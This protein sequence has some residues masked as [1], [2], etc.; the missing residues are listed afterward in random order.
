MNHFSPIDP[1]HVVT[2]PHSPLPG[3]QPMSLGLTGEELFLV[4][5]PAPA[6]LIR[7]KAE[8]RVMKNRETAASRA[9]DRVATIAV[10]SHSSFIGKSFT[11]D[12]DGKLQKHTSATFYDGSVAIRRA[13]TAADLAAI[14]GGL[15]PSRDVLALG[16]L[17]DGRDA[18]RVT[19]LGRATGDQIARTKQNFLHPAAP[20]WA[21]LD[22]DLGTATPRARRQIEA[23]GGP[24]SALYAAVP[25]LRTSCHVVRPSSS[26]GVH[27]EGDQPGEVVGWHVLVK[28]QDATT[29]DHFIATVELRLWL[30]GLAWWAVSSSGSRLPRGLVDNTVGGPE[31]LIFTADPVLDPGVLRDAP[32]MQ[33]FEGEALGTLQLAPEDERLAEELS[34]LEYRLTKPEADRFYHKWRVAAAW[35]IVAKT[36]IDFWTAFDQVHLARSRG[37]LSDNVLFNK[38]DGSKGRIGDV[39][40]WAESLPEASRTG[41][42][43][44]VCDP[45]ETYKDGEGKFAVIWGAD[46]E[47]PVGLSFAH[48]G[49]VQYRFARYMEDG[50]GPDGGLTADSDVD[51]DASPVR[52]AAG[53]DQAITAD[54]VRGLREATRD[55]HFDTADM[56]ALPHF[57]A[58]LER[59]QLAA[60]ATLTMPNVQLATVA[61]LVGGGVAVQPACKGALVQWLSASVNANGAVSGAVVHE[62]DAKGDVLRSTT[63]LPSDDIRAR[64]LWSA[65]VSGVVAGDRVFACEEPLAA[66]LLHSHCDTPVIAGPFAEDD[67]RKYRVPLAPGVDVVA[68]SKLPEMGGQSAWNASPLR[69]ALAGHQVTVCLSDGA[70]LWAYRNDLQA[71][72]KW[73]YRE[74]YVRFQDFVAALGDVIKDSGVVTGP[75]CGLTERR[76]GVGL[77]EA[78]RT[79]SE[80]MAEAFDA[81]PRR[82]LRATTTTDGDECEGDGH[83]GD[84]DEYECA[85]YGLVPDD[86]SS[87]DG[88]LTPAERM[89]LASVEEYDTSHRLRKPNIS[90][91]GFVSVTVG[92]GK[93]HTALEQITRKLVD[94]PE[95]RVLWRAPTHKLIDE[96]AAKAADMGIPVSKWRGTARSD[97]L[98]GDLPWD[99]AEQKPRARDLDVDEGGMN[100][101]GIDGNGVDAD[102]GGDCGGCLARA[103]C[104]RLGDVQEARKLGRSTENVCEGIKGDGS[105]ACPFSP[106]HE[107]NEGLKRGSLKWIEQT[108]GY[109]TQGVGDAGIFFVAGD[110]ALARRVPRD[111]RPVDAREG[112]ESDGPADFDLVIID[113]TSPAAWTSVTRPGQGVPLDNL[114]FDFAAKLAAAA[115]A[116]P[117]VDQGKRDKHPWVRH[118]LANS[119]LPIERMQDPAPAD[120]GHPGAYEAGKAAMIDMRSTWAAMEVADQDS[121]RDSDGEDSGPRDV[122]RA[123]VSARMALLHGLLLEKARASGGTGPCA[124]T[125]GDLNQISITGHW[126]GDLIR[127]VNAYSPVVPNGLIAQAG[128]RDARESAGAVMALRSEI[129]ATTRVLRA[130]KQGV[131]RL[132]PLWWTAGVSR[133]PVRG[134]VGFGGDLAMA[135]DAPSAAEIEAT[136]VLS[137]MLVPLND[138]T[139]SLWRVET[140]LSKAPSPWL[141]DVPMLVLD[142]TFEPGLMG[143]VFDGIKAVADVTIEDGDGAYHVM[144]HGQRMSYAQGAVKTPVFEIA[145]GVVMSDEQKRQHDRRM[146]QENNTQRALVTAEMIDF[147]SGADAKP[148]AA[149]SGIILPKASESWLDEQD[150]LGDRPVMHHGDTAG[151]NTM[152]RLPGLVLHARAAVSRSAAEIMAFALTGRPVAEL[153]A[154]GGASSFYDNVPRAV[155]MRAPSAPIVLQERHP[156]PMVEAVRRSITNTTSTQSAGRVRTV[157]R[158]SDAPCL[159]VHTSDVDSGFVIDQAISP[160]MWR[161]I[162]SE[163]GEILTSGLWISGAYVQSNLRAA[164]GRSEGWEMPREGTTADFIKHIDEAF[165]KGTLTML[166]QDRD[167]SDFVRVK[168]QMPGSR[169]A[170]DAWVWASDPLTAQVVLQERFP[171][172]GVRTLTKWSGNEGKMDG[173]NKGSHDVD[174]LFISYDIGETRREE[175]MDGIRNP[176]SS[177]QKRIQTT[178]AD[179][180][181]VPLTK[182]ALLTASPG[183]WSLGLIEKSRFL[184]AIKK[185]RGVDPD[186]LRAELKKLNLIVGSQAAYLVRFKLPSNSGRSH[187]QYAVVWAPPHAIPDRL[188]VVLGE[189]ENLEII[190]GGLST[191]ATTNKGKQKCR[192]HKAN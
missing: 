139:G 64:V 85:P 156:D 46:D 52:R 66:L 131:D 100:V 127:D 179:L 121:G 81:M 34:I 177:D 126:L 101:A 1:Q 105:D 32:E 88:D 181:V 188:E 165:D 72:G 190:G 108:C 184:K 113:E 56:A 144:V 2:A 86:D 124:L 141:D 20:G 110:G 76:R 27:V 120:Q 176:A 147:M 135:I 95:M 151:K 53:I 14:I 191:T 133:E 140:A 128:W 62:I 40:D 54:V 21:L 16:R 157:R 163:F 68:M 5:N 93:T 75:G 69:S 57:A 30:M 26:G 149:R 11:L 36:G 91:R 132:A 123:D 102:G 9:W 107:R 159:V 138:E 79:L 90:M 92:G 111:L 22:I 97:V 104:R 142:A 42:L 51:P 48:G 174:A 55:S 103:M 125:F 166:G 186:L 24:L 12:E 192:F 98:R 37:I 167:L 71:S 39:L 6:K 109:R 44:Y 84:G 74:D 173:R 61:D 148:L 189:V 65:G 152:E 182:A 178:A 47:T 7:E 41:T 143:Y 106:A 17:S 28:L 158:G 35:A 122:I 50:A 145:E 134:D 78:Q 63:L 58:L 38:G 161:A 60:D 114:T 169:Y 82:T 129:R 115:V 80:S 25:E 87:V 154:L 118:R 172:C 116:T 13:D 175:E 23:H 183:T 187:W 8:Q 117:G 29:I 94:Y 180:G 67:T 83:D 170:A 19:T 155:R 43:T 146:T 150:A 73:A 33:A 89:R 4:G 137:A 18:A 45:F 185:G 160:E 130:L 96:T 153:S 119:E 59:L 77:G 136:P 3:R 168:L 31:R 164:L 15:D 171:G 99:S 70:G 49:R 162:T 112:L 10:L